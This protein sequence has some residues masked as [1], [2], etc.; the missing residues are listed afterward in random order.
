MCSF[1]LSLNKN[2]A[3]S[4]CTVP[5][6]R[7]R[8]EW[9]WRWLGIIS[10][11]RRRMSCSFLLAGALPSV[12]WRWRGSLLARGRAGSPREWSLGVTSAKCFSRAGLWLCFLILC[13]APV[14]SSC[15]PEPHCC[16]LPHFCPSL[17]G[18]GRCQLWPERSLAM[19]FFQLWPGQ[20]LVVKV[21]GGGAGG[22]F[23]PH[24]D[25][26]LQDRPTFRPFFPTIFFLSSLSW[27]SYRGILV[28]LEGRDP[29]MCTFGGSRV[30]VGS[31]RTPNLDTI[32][33]MSSTSMIQYPT[34]LHYGSEVK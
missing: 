23:L 3:K 4:H 32:V 15:T 6:M 5:L 34:S 22:H 28:V 25:R 2:W 20:C 30:V 9:S 33:G 18:N 14:D 1:S 19:L 7:R 31:P 11:V 13:S 24:L 17:L 10:L 27:E 21:G 16:I 29:Q 26:L 8:A 12:E